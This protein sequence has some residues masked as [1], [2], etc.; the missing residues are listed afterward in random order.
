MAKLTIEAKLTYAWWWPIYKACLI[1]TVW[2]TQREPDWDKFR[3]WHDRACTIF[4][5]RVKR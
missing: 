1:A 5:E 3:K 2:I 4:F